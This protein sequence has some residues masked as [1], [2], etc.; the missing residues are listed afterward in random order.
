VLRITALELIVAD[1]GGVG[2][3]LLDERILDVLDIQLVRSELAVEERDSCLVRH[4]EL[5]VND[6][7]RMPL[8]RLGQ[9]VH[10]LE[11]GANVDLSDLGGIGMIL[12]DDLK[13]GVEVTAGVTAAGGNLR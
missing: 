12:V 8:A 7:F 1:D 13:A 10:G 6:V 3:H 4:G 11:G 5:Q 9:Q 2:D